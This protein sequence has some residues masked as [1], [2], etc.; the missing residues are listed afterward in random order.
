M[1]NYIPTYELRAFGKNYIGL[2][3]DA[4][5]AK[6]LGL[7]EEFE[8]YGDEMDVDDYVE[9][10]LEG[11]ELAELYATMQ[12]ADKEKYTAKDEEKEKEEQKKVSGKNGAGI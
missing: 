1:S 6:Q 7:E 11:D 12:S 9:L 10:A 3:L 4:H 8:Q 2:K 5:E